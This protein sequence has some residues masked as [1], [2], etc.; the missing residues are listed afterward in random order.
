MVSEKENPTAVKYGT[1]EYSVLLRVTE[2]RGFSS[3]TDFHVSV[4]GKDAKEIVSAKPIDSH[5]F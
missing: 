5:V 2:A 1:G 3:E 4:L